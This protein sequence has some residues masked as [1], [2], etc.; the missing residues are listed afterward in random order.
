LFNE[1]KIW[2]DWTR[3]FFPV[4]IYLNLFCVFLFFFCVHGW[5][6]KSILEIVLAIFLFISVSN[7]IFFDH[8]IYL[9]IYIHVFLIKTIIFIFFSA[10][11]GIKN[12]QRKIFSSWNQLNNWTKIIPV[13]SMD[14]GERHAS[15]LICW[16]S[17]FKLSF[18][19]YTTED[20][21]NMKMTSI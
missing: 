8:Q 3:I 6:S 2:T 13:C 14:R 5:L 15:C 20:V 9:Y 16:P 19:N 12:F 4:E 21:N 1:K 7:W 10:A 11:L 18:H 17:V